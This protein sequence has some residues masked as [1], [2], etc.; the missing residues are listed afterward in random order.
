MMMYK[1]KRRKRFRRFVDK[2]IKIV[3]LSAVIFIIGYVL[4]AGLHE[5]TIGT[6][7]VILVLICFIIIFVPEN[8]F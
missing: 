2:V 7:M 5:Y 6:L 4:Q 8:K 3:L 1:I